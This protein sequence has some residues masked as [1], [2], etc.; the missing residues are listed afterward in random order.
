MGQVI[1]SRKHSKLGVASFLIGMFTLL[2]VVVG[3]F[4]LIKGAATAPRGYTSVFYHIDI[5]LTIQSLIVF[6]TLSF[7]IVGVILGIVGA[8]QKNGKKLFSIL[9]IALNSL[10]F[11]MMAAVMIRF[12]IFWWRGL[13]HD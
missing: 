3:A 2:V 11:L 1:A 13:T 10:S 7:N 4:L 6:T 8:V 5:D 12:M 9:G